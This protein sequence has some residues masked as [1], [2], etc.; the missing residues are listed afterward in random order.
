MI[1]IDTKNVYLDFSF[2]F[3]DWFPTKDGE[4]KNPGI[5]LLFVMI[6]YMYYN[7]FPTNG[8]LFV[9]LMKVT[10]QYMLVFH[11]TICCI[12]FWLYI[13]LV[14]THMNCRAPSFELNKTKSISQKFTIIV[15]S[16]LLFRF[17]LLMCMR[18]LHMQSPHSTIFFWMTVKL[19]RKEVGIPAHQF[20]FMADIIV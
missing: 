2:S 17:L 15:K 1:D 11:I 19:N 5:R 3:S 13:R 8:F 10:R 4:Q 6:I 12:L 16:L 18:L 14:A 9:R 20:K 7:W